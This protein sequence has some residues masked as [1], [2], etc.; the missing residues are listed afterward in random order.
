MPDL[1][2]AQQI[3]QEQQQLT[4]K[5][6]KGLVRRANRKEKENQQ[7]MVVEARPSAFSVSFI[8]GCLLLH[9]IDVHMLIHIFP[10]SLGNCNDILP[11]SGS[12]DVI[13]DPHVAPESG[14]GQ[15]YPARMSMQRA[16]DG[17]G[18]CEL[19]RCT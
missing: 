11:Q 8:E 6:V 3:A 16:A 15:M 7:R 4:P 17:L 13:R 14:L 5:E 2:P 12:T 10:E 1:T 18:G 9:L 19:R